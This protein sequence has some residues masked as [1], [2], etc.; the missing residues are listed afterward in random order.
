MLLLRDLRMGGVGWFSHP[1]SLYLMLAL[2][3]GPVLPSLWC[4]SAQQLPTSLLPGLL[5]PPSFYLPDPSSHLAPPTLQN[6]FLP[7]PP[8]ASLALGQAQPA[9][10]GPTVAS[11]PSPLELL[12]LLPGCRK[13]LLPSVT[14]AASSGLH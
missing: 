6:P 9:L 8:E 5:S 3:K 7:L 12:V 1:P 4:R 10:L 14:V 2:A 11:Q 13:P